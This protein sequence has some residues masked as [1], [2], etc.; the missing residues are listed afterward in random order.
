MQRAIRIRRPGGPEALELE[1]AELA[2]PGRG[3]ALVLHTAIG[4][5]Y[6]DVYH[7]SGLYPLPSLPHG[8]GMEAAGVVQSVGPGVTGVQVGQRVAYASGP[9]GAY[10]EARLIRAD[11]LVPLPAEIDDRTAAASLL[12]GMTVEYLVR[13]THRAEAGET[14][15]WHAAAGGVGLIACQWL[16]HLGVTVIGTVGSEAK[17][18]LAREHGCTHTILYTREDFVPRVRELTGGRGVSAVYDSVG[19]DTFARSLDCLARRGMMVSF[20][21]AS[22]RP[23]PIDPGLLSAKGSLF[24]TRPTLVDYTGT[25]EEL[26]ASA[27]ALFDVISRGAVKVRISETWELAEAAR[28]HTALEA[29][30]TWGST[31]LLP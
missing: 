31:L 26:L 3:E 25:R 24:L 14:V 15:L 4:V 27:A 17:A 8:L 20:G 7:R 6:I 30:R 5:N 23:E 19:R 2:E 21:N 10:A 13:R 11:R 16:A 22:G 28:A 29:R 1:V 12:K 9:P 18:Q